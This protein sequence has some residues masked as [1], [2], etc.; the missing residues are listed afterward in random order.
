MAST[1]KARKPKS[2]EALVDMVNAPSDEMADTLGRSYYCYCLESA[3]LAVHQARLI[4]AG[5][6]VDENHEL[7]LIEQL[8][9][10]A[11]EAS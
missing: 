8:L 9:V 1:R 3:L 7:P 6:K 11:W 2:V 5:D 10:D 4:V